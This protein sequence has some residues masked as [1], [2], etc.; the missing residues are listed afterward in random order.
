MLAYTIQIYFD[1]S[2]YCDMATGIALMFNIKLPMNFNS[3]YKATTIVEFWKRWHISL[4]RFFTT[5]IYIPL[6]GNRKGNIRTYINIFIVFLISGIWHGANYTFI[7][8][9]IL[10]GIANII[11]RFFKEK[12][13]K[14]NPVFN[15]IC[16]FGFVNL[17]W[18]IFR[19][20]SINDAIL[21][22]KKLFS[23]NF[24]YTPIML[25]ITNAF[26]TAEFNVI[27]SVFKVI[28][29]YNIPIQLFFIFAFIAILCMKNTNE[30]IENFK[31]T[32]KK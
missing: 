21:F 32:I 5:Y 22:F 31:P 7:L 15:W 20:N 28:K 29:N 18:V 23:F 11:T 16:T 3:P 30:K 17:T 14:L 4:T 8:W 26:Y 19:A 2:G 9:G 12:I 10:H 24:G 25:R 27:N 1:F 13:E 6:G